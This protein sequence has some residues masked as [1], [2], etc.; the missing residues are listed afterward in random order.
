LIV[1]CSALSIL[2]NTTEARIGASSANQAQG[3]RI[4]MVSGLVKVGNKAGEARKVV[5]EEF[6]QLQEEGGQSIT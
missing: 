6:Q 5:S 4:E 3:D 2:S 1:A